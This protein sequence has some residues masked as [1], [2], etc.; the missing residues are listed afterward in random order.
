MLAIT[1]PTRSSFFTSDFASRAAVFGCIFFS[2]IAT[3]PLEESMQRWPCRAADAAR[4]VAGKLCAPR[5]GGT[6]IT[7]WRDFLPISRFLI[8]VYPISRQTMCRAPPVPLSISWPAACSAVARRAPPP[9]VML[10]STLCYIRTRRATLAKR[11]AAC[12]AHLHAHV[13]VQ[14][15]LDIGLC[16]AC[17]HRCRATGSRMHARGLFT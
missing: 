10:A 2:S 8:W 17:Q 13:H 6:R 9:R 1:L 16:A 7:A 15:C 12:A 11:A 5:S 14:G 4:V 3:T